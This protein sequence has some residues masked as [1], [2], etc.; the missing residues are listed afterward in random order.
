MTRRFTLA[1]L[2]LLAGAAVDAHPDRREPHLAW[3]AAHNPAQDF[4]RWFMPTT[5]GHEPGVPPPAEGPD[6][7][8]T[9][10]FFGVDRHDGGD[11]KRRNQVNVGLA[12]SHNLS[13]IFPPSLFDTRPE[14][15]PLVNG[16]RERPSSRRVNWN[17][18]LGSETSALHAAGAARAFFAQNPDAV[19]FSVGINDALRY[20][21]SPET[22][23]H[24]YSPRYFREM[25]IYTDLVFAFTNRVA[26]LTDDLGPD[27]HIGAL[28]YYWTE[29]PPA[30][31]IHPRVIP[32]LTADR[33]Q[34]FDSDFRREEREVMRAWANSGARRVGLYDYAHGY[35]FL[36]P[37]LYPTTYAQH[38]R[39]ARRLGFTDYFA[40]FATNWGLDG[41]QPWL[42]AQML[43]DPE[44][45]P[46][47][48]LDEYYRRFYR[49]AARPMRAFFEKCEAVWAAQGEPVYWLKHYR[50]DSQAALFSAEVRRDLRALLDQAARAA[51]DDPVVAARVAVSAAAFRVSERY[52]EMHEAREALA[53]AVIAAESADQPDLSAL[54]RL[55]ANDRE[56]RAAFQTTLVEVR[57]TQ[58]LAIAPRI[59]IDFERSD[60][61]PSADRL[62]ANDARVPDDARQLLHDAR[63]LGPLRPDLHL[64]GLL[65]EP[66]LTGG[67]RARTE[68]REGLLV[69]LREPGDGR[70][71]VLRFENNKT[72]GV[73]QVV[74]LPGAG[75]GLAMSELSG[76]ISLTNQVIFRVLWFG[77]DHNLLRE[78]ARQIPP[79]SWRGA[80]LRT[81]LDPPEGAA[82]VGVMLNIQ[83][84]QAGDWLEWSDVSVQ[85]W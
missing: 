51:A 46:R 22:R 7:F 16:R 69:E 75:R 77:S 48:L 58:P 68:P 3:R 76:E 17:P 31:P 43:R 62:I 52:V 47:R 45:S 44:Q 19:S 39:E 14:L 6:A 27:K 36:V 21:D 8:L 70:P 10:Y 2:S 41:P 60:W 28:A 56:A 63:W 38:L 61:G 65:Y 5:L 66:G 20:G 40:E 13:R 50:N 81:P 42:V 54:A 53:R 26:E 85:W 33:S 29:H 15:F 9:R 11:W 83:H 59:P 71:R 12:F 82:F 24:V 37:R 1:L 34:W 23:R 25:P 80:R 4:E 49:D 18:E 35:G 57:A 79:G 55:R 30:F 32:Y 64:A 84:Q 72:T 74:A 73:D 67:W 78:D